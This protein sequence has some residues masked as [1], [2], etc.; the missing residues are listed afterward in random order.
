[1]LGG[2]QPRRRVGACCLRVGVCGGGWLLSSV[3]SHL[4]FVHVCCVVGVWLGGTYGQRCSACCWVLRR[5][6]V[7][8]VFFGGR[9]RPGP[10]NAPPYFSVVVG[11][12]GGGC[13]VG[14]WW[15]VECC[16]VDASILLCLVLW[17][18]KFWPAC[19]WRC[20]LALCVVLVL[21]W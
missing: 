20:C 7:G 4:F 6:P 1:V 11:G 14:V 2:V 13:G 17:C 3:G 5:H 16:I 19:V 18:E 10:S 15:C 8:V 12:C 21:L 9:S